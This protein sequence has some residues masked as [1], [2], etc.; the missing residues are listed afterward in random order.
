M[1]E[2][3][4]CAPLSNGQRCPKDK[5][6]KSSIHCED[7]Y[8]HGIRLYKLYKQLCK[9]SEQF[10]LA[11]TEDTTLKQIK[12]LNQGYLIN[13][14]AYNG[15][16][17]HRIYGLVPKC[18]DYGHDVQFDMLLSNIDYCEAELSILYDRYFTEKLQFEILKDKEAA[19]G[20]VNVEE[21][22]KESG[23]D[24]HVQ[25]VINTVKDFK[26][27]RIQDQK[28]E[29]LILKQYI[30][31]NKVFIN[32][33]LVLV[34][35]VISQFRSHMRIKRQYEFYQ[36]I[37]VYGMI[38]TMDMA[39]E[40]FNTSIQNRN[41]VKGFDLGDPSLKKYT[42]ARN[43]LLDEPET[44]LHFVLDVMH[45]SYPLISNF[46]VVAEKY[47]NSKGIDPVR[48]SAIL[49]WNPRDRKFLMAY[50]PSMIVNIIASAKKFS[51][52]EGITDVKGTVFYR[53]LPS[54]ETP[55]KE[56]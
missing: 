31:E 11:H 5:I 15:R 12:Y 4:C 55:D 49:A 35:R 25:E 33:K 42:S 50:V 41:I 24:L 53:E 54:L 8:P 26:Q 51:Q 37:S 30:E 7:H 45:R 28:D 32:E 2:E 19:K 17:E 52:I 23:N 14:R 6:D 10:D 18:H 27:R 22:V 3:R 20:I 1:S 46:F 44:G 21:E 36:I 34:D 9:M 40:S 38:I 29:D 48:V 43:Y 56:F 47:W 39:V 13:R 16:M